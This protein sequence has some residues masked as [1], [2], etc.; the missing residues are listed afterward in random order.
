MNTQ[1]TPKRHK[2]TPPGKLPMPEGQYRTGI[3][4]SGH[5]IC[6]ANIAAEFVHL[7]D[8]MAFLLAA[9]LGTGDLAAT[10]HLLK[11]I[12]S[13]RGRVD[14]MTD[15][16]QKAPSNALA[17]ST[18]DDILK[19]FAAINSRRNAYIH[20]YW[21]TFVDNST[22]WLSEGTSGSTIFLKARAVEIDELNA[23]MVRIHQCGLSLLSGPLN[24]LVMAG[25]VETY[26][27]Q[28][29]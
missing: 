24:D 17:P 27:P 12:K 2:S 4:S 25:K 26:Q 3:W 16:L 8:Q 6:V 10:R 13:P 21:W 5:A 23:L 11:A 29:P 28:R 19:E 18:Y 15:L 7:E 14:V 1:A 22:T 20:G 9:L